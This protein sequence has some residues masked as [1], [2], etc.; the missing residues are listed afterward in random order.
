[1][2]LVKRNWV[3]NLQYEQ[4]IQHIKNNHQHE[5]NRNLMHKGFIFLHSLKQQ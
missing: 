1:M 3:S 4:Q 2:S 5:K